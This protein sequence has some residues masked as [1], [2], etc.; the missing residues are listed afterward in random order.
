[1]NRASIEADDL[2]RDIR[3]AFSEVGRVSDDRLFLQVQDYLWVEA[4]LAGVGPWHEV[5]DSA[6]MEECSALT[7]VTSEGFRFFL[8]VYMCW[9]VRNPKSSYNTVDHTIYALNLSN[10][11]AETRS[12]MLEQFSV[13]SISQAGAV[14]RFLEWA[15]SQSDSVDAPAAEAALAA[16]WCKFDA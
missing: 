10:R 9:V 6:I 13:L 4:L 2:L 8:P 15:A 12:A 16:Y 14:R 1:M 11:C 3:A 5:A 7:A